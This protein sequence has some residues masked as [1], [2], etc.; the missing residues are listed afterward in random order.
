MATRNH[1]DELTAAVVR[2]LGI[3]C[4]LTSDQVGGETSGQVGGGCS[5]RAGGG[6]RGGDEGAEGDHVDRN[7]YCLGG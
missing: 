5:E 2:S 7:V 6:H 3:G 4:A 1:M